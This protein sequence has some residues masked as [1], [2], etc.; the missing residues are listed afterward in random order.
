MGE[1]R[2]VVIGAGISGLVAIKSCLEMGFKPCCF[3]KQS[4]IG[5][6]W[7]Y[8]EHINRGEASAMYDNLVTNTSK[9]MMCFSDFSFPEDYP[10]YLLIHHVIKYLRDY[11]KHYDLE[12]YICFDTDVTGVKP[13]SDSA[14]V[15]QWNVTT[16]SLE[17]Q[18][19][20]TVFDGVMVCTGVHSNVIMPTF[21]GM[22]EFK[23]QVVHSNAFRKGETVSGKNVLV[24]GASHSAGDISTQCSYYANMTYICMRSGC[25]LL[26]R[27]G[28][29]GQPLDSL[30]SRG[31][32]HVPECIQAMVIQRMFESR[33]D[34]DS[35]GVRSTKS[36]FTASKI[37]CDTFP[38]RIMN[39]TIKVKDNVKMFT[40]TC[41]KFVDGTYIDNIDIVICATGYRTTFPFLDPDI[42]DDTRFELYKHILSPKYPTLAFIGII[43]VLGGATSPVAEL[44]ARWATSV[45]SGNLRIP[46]LP[47]RQRDA[48]HR[49][50]SL[51]KRHGFLKL[52][53]SHLPYQEEL[54]GDI[55]ARPS[56]ALFLTDPKL[57]AKVFFGP[58]YPSSYRLQGPHQWPGARKAIMNAWE[59]TVNPT[60]TRQLDVQNHA[61][62]FKPLLV[63]TVSFLIMFIVYYISN[64]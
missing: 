40:K 62:I 10:P 59:N 6:V 33:A 30:V 15:G 4:S 26:S 35:L 60:K 24:I 56:Y 64:F 52:A 20:T 23:G 61:S 19:V 13:V 55:G 49:I 45:F 58:A 32:L 29:K 7:V 42:F 46:E 28:P 12:K 37:M 57:A 3:E 31:T 43:S 50:D 47:T 17:G 44:Q 63:V 1:K 51:I 16:R 39:G 27:R 11:A 21:P 54:A 48:K 14:I 2:I 18:A 9:E 25:Y 53:I 8:D 22:D 41:V 36:I 5:G 38:D 34:F